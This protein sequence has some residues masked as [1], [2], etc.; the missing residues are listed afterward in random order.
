MSDPLVCRLLRGSRLERGG[1]LSRA[2][3]AGSCPGPGAR[4]GV[5]IRASSTKVGR[6][7][8]LWTVR[9]LEV[10]V[11]ERQERVPM[12]LPCWVPKEERQAS[13]SR[14]CEG[15]RR[16][17]N[18]SRMAD[19]AGARCLSYGCSAWMCRRARCALHHFWLIQLNRNTGGDATC[20]GVS[21]PCFRR[22]WQE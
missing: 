18:T 19:T 6:G 15:G 16:M 1:S 2:G 11:V 12:G 10:R 21:L 4:W 13:D 3:C 17:R 9:R 7:G 5:T 8:D 20:S 14:P 22:S